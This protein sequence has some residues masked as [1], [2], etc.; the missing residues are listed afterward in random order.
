MPSPSIS[1]R[2]FV[3]VSTGTILALAGC[4]SETPG[5]ES[6]NEASPTSPGGETKTSTTNSSDGTIRVESLSVVD[7]VLYPLAGTHPH[8]HSRATIQYVILRMTSRF[9]RETV[10]DRLTLELDAEPVPLAERQPVP[11][12]HDT[13]D[14]AFAVS[15][16][17]TFDEGRVLFDQTELRL[18]SDAT[19]DRLNNP[20]VFEVSEPSVSP[21]EVHAGE[22]IQ[23]T[24]QFSVAN[25]GDG[26]G[27][28]GASLS[29][30]FSSGAETITTTLD[31]G[32]TRQITEA[33]T[34]TGEGDK[35][36]VRLDWGTD[37]W[38]TDIPVVGTATDSESP[39]PTPAPK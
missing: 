3:E 6:P 21:K 35:A 37:E 14:L 30:N 18:L 32:S 8:V 38:V 16:T 33:V 13:T 23:P 20:P 24:V 26:R 25:T 15:K 10:R 29:G 2:R 31:A 5:S 12:E 39:T 9:P 4:S 22:R 36:T 7:F 34:I 28:F 27:T 19:L 11:W 1:R 17:D